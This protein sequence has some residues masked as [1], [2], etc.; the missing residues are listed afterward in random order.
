VSTSSYGLVTGRV[1]ALALDPSDAT[2][3]RLYVGTT[4]GGVWAASNAGAANSSSVVF[5]PLTDSVNALSGAADSSISIGALTVQP[6]GT[7]VILAGTGDP[8]DV[9]D[10]YYGAGIL[11]SIDGGSTWTLI[12]QTRDVEDGLGGQDFA[13][14]GEGFAGFA[15]STVNSQMVVAAVSQAY[16]GTLVDAT[17]SDLSYEGLY[18]SADS[19]ATWH[20]ATI[21]DGSGKDVQGPLDAFAQPDGN[22]ATAVVWNPVRQVFVAAMRFHGYYESADGKTWTRI[23]TQ[24]GAGLAASAC[25]NNLGGIGSI[26]CPIFRGALAVNPTT[27][28]TFAWTVDVDNQ[29]QGLWQ[30]QCGLSNGACGNGAISFGRQWGTAA[31]ETSTIEGAATISNGNYNLALA[32]VPSQQDTLLMAGANDVWKCSLAAGCVWRNTTNAT[33]CMSAQVGEF[34][35][36][37]AWNAANPLEIFAGNDSGLWRSMDGISETGP[38][39]SSSDASHFQNLNGGLGSLAEVVSMSAVGDT[40]YAMMAGL[41]VNGTAGVKGTAATADWPQI[42]SGY[43]GPVAIDPKDNNNWYVNSEAGVSIYACSQAATCTPADFGTSPTVTN[44]DV[45]LPDG[46]MPAAAVFEV[47]PLDSTQ[48]LIGTCQLWRGPANGTAWTAS[49]A[50]TAVL[51]S[52]ADGQCNGDALIRSMS[53]MAL[54]GGGEIVYLGMYGA[55]NGGANL[56]GHVLSVLI[57]GS[58]G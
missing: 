54:P 35:H 43:G 2:G 48:L 34:Q 17:Q 44:A 46:A 19:G 53:A 22:A 57:N 50:V 52:G 28:D 41:G 1:S 30:D 45:N 33:T 58:S 14:V 26:A 5:T 6:G 20:L 51:D 24:P 11:R 38:A 7:G 47:D 29:D 12:Q 55:A 27:G 31:L 9:L 36:A 15:W 16:E 8:N 10:S 3:N 21:T 39:C 25:P 42:L 32:A 37:L 13:F 18:Y 4:G 49:N 40:P 23:A 56:P